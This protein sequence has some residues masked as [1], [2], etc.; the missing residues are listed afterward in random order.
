MIYFCCV[1]ESSTHDVKKNKLFLRGTLRKWIY[2]FLAAGCTKQKSRK[3]H[4]NR[5][6]HDFI[7]LGLFFYTDIS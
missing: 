2:G 6:R 7:D 3:D 4:F 5:L 1:R